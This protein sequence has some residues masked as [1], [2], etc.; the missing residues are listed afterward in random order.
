MKWIFGRNAT[1]SVVRGDVR[2]VE[3]VPGTVWHRLHKL[4][5][6]SF[7]TTYFDKCWKQ[8]NVLDDIFLNF[9]THK[10]PWHMLV[11]VVG[12]FHDFFPWIFSRNVL[13][14]VKKADPTESVIMDTIRGKKIYYNEKRTRKNHVKIY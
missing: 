4:S 1:L 2:M 11:V 5:S 9:K 10:W 8:V 3:V 12:S 14:A 6:H 13:C 7:I